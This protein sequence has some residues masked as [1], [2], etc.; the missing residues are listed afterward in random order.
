MTERLLQWRGASGTEAPR[1]STCRNA[2]VFTCGPDSPHAGPVPA[3]IG[4]DTTRRWILRGMAAAPVA[5]ATESSGPKQQ[6]AADGNPPSLQGRSPEARPAP[7][8][9][10]KIRAWMP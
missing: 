6:Q 9:C 8:P 1:L 4:M 5:A 7:P 10:A 2:R 3:V